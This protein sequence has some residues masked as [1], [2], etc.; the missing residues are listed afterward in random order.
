MKPVNKT[1]KAARER[2][3]LT[4]DDVA[5]RSG[6]SWWSSPAEA[7]ETAAET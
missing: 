4:L 1:I 7:A 3:G 6:L 2:L 5:E